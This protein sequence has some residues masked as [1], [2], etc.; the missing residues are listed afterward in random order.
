MTDWPDKHWSEGFDEQTFLTEAEWKTYH[1]RLAVRFTD[2]SLKKPVCEICGK[3]GT[4]KN[5]LQ[6]A[7]RIGFERGVHFLALTPDYLDRQENL[8]TAHRQGCN[9]KAE[10]SLADALKLLRTWGVAHLPPFL[11]DDVRILWTQGTSSAI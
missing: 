3:P 9:G 2:Q 11:P 10:L 1:R 6:L 8:V 4:D 7:H 5:P